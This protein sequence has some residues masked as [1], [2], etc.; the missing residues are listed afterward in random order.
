M[1]V[2]AFPVI[3]MNFKSI[4]ADYCTEKNSLQFFIES[5]ATWF[6]KHFISFEFSIIQKC[7]VLELVSQLEE[8]P[9]SSSG[10]A[11]LSK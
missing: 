2:F 5:S 11:S 8:G 9:F 7:Y 6:S 3:K 1:G 4:T 10:K